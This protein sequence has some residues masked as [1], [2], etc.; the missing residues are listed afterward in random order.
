MFFQLFSVN[1]FRWRIRG[2][3]AGNIFPFSLGPCD[4]KRFGH[5]EEINNKGIQAA[6][7]FSWKEWILIFILEG[8][9]QSRQFKK[10]K[11]FFSCSN[12]H[13]QHRA[14][15]FVLSLLTSDYYLTLYQAGCLKTF[16]PNR[17]LPS[18]SFFRPKTLQSSHYKPKSATIAFFSSPPFVLLALSFS[19]F[20][21]P[22]Y[23]DSWYFWRKKPAFWPFSL[24]W[25]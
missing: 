6:G 23:C 22:R 16:L 24:T 14:S 12:E 5:A 17:L 20:L 25:L 15:L 9:L 13:L 19:P 7:N 11:C 1:S 21:F 8:V 4:P 2:K 3:R 10:A 18:N